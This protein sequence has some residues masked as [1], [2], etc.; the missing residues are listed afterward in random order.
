MLGLV[1]SRLDF[2][3]HDWSRC[4]ADSGPDVVMESG[5]DWHGL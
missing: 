4:Y 2:W 1:G 5:L 3:I